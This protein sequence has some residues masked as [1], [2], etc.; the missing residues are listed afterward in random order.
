MSR[1]SSP[2]GWM[3]SPFSQAFPTHHLGPKLFRESQSTVPILG[4]LLA[5]APLREPL[6]QAQG[7][8]QDGGRDVRRMIERLH[9]AC[10]R[11]YGQR[12]MAQAP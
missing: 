1:P 6:R 11:H 10:R 8:A 12:K 7:I 2:V 3:A 4:M 5:A 9:R